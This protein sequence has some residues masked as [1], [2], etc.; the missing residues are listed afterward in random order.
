MYENCTTEEKEYSALECIGR[1]CDE[2]SER[3]EFYSRKTDSPQVR[4][5]LQKLSAAAR[6]HSGSIRSALEAKS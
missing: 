2:L 3:F 4:D 5:E 1:G 6:N